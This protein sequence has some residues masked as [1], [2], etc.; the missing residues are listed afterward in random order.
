MFTVAMCLCNIGVA[1]FNNN[2][3]IFLE[4]ETLVSFFVKHEIELYRSLGITTE[5]A[6]IVN[7]STL[8]LATI[9]TILGNNQMRNLLI[10]DG[11]QN[12]AGRL[13]TLLLYITYRYG[14]R[15]VSRLR[16]EARVSMQYT[17]T[18]DE[19]VTKALDAEFN[20]FWLIPFIK[21]SYLALSILNM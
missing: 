2:S 21:R 16:K 15:A 6:A 20:T 19:S 14:T 12:V 1:M 4:I 8:D 7:M 11:I 18:I 5:N 3:V 10:G 13:K 9:N 17:Y